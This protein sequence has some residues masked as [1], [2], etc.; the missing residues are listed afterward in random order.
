MKK[1]KLIYSL[2]AVVAFLLSYATPLDAQKF[3]V[4]PF[5]GYETSGKINSI[6][7]GVFRINDGLAYGGS[8]SYGSGEGFR[9]ELTYTRQGS[10]LTYTIDDVTDHICD[11]AVNQISFGAVYEYNPED[12]VVPFGRFAL[13]SSI[14]E[15]LDEEIE[16]EKI[17]H[18]SFAGGTKLN[19]SDRIGFRLQATLY[20]PLFFEG[21]YFSEGPGGEEPEV[22]TKVAGVQG[23]FTGGIIFRF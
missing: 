13:G 3:E 9:F 21:L 19:L 18:F 14:Y 12:K 5:V 6:S 16:S 17:F 22:G 2:S 20:L 1:I 10:D 8:V 11:L 15:P 7:G 4:I 23:E